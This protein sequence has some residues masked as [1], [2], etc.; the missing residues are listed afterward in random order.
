MRGPG[1]RLALQGP[2]RGRWPGRA[3]GR[4]PANQALG[5]VSDDILVAEVR[6]LHPDIAVD[7]SWLFMNSKCPRRLLQRR[8][9][10]QHPGAF[11]GSLQRATNQTGRY[12]NVLTSTYSVR[13]PLPG[14]LEAR[15]PRSEVVNT[16]KCPALPT[17]R[18]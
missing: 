9:S 12:V 17:F 4:R 2:A 16:V 11:T 1:P 3:G 14:R 10:P 5:T 15:R 13:P 8:N 6:S 7:R 18:E